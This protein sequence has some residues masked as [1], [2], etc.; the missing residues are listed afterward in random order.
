VANLFERLGRERPTPNEKTNEQQPVESDQ[1]RQKRLEAR[2]D[3]LATDLR[4]F[5]PLSTA[6]ECTFHN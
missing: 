1:T 5:R 2:L 3:T 4:R 6:R